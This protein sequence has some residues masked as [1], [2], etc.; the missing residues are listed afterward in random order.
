MLNFKLLV[1]ITHA[2]LFQVIAISLNHAHH[3][4]WTAIVEGKCYFM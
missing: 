3:N 4:G 1:C 2:I